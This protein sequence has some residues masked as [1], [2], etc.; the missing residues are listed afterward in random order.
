M[1]N[2]YN[3]KSLG[4]KL[5]GFK[6]HPT[7]ILISILLLFTASIRAQDNIT[8]QSVILG[9]TTVSA[10]GSI[11]LNA[12]FEVAPG[13]TF[14]ASIGPNQAVN[15]S[16]NI[17]PTSSNSVP[18]SGTSSENYIKSITYREPLTSTPTS[19]TS[20][21]HNED[22]QYFDGL[23]RPVQAIGVGASPEG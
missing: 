1:K 9:N 6:N 17:T 19:G 16:A 7:T 18:A 22:I 12:G 4:L 10:P 15:S 5:S 3:N 20:F 11:T 14:T 8:I 21:K 2:I 23:G 13:A